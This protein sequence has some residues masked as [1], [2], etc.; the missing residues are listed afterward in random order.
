MMVMKEP[1]IRRNVHRKGL[2]ALPTV[3]RTDLDRI[4]RERIAS[5]LE[6]QQQKDPS[7]K[8]VPAKVRDQL[9]RDG[10]AVIRGL[11]APELVDELRERVFKTVIRAGLG[12]D[13]R[14]DAST[15][16]L[17]RAPRNPKDFNGRESVRRV[18]TS[19]PYNVLVSHA[20]KALRLVSGPAWLMQTRY[21]RVGLPGGLDFRLP[22][23]QDAF[24]LPESKT[25]RTVWIPLHRCPRNLGGLRVVPRSHQRGA[26]LHDG[27]QGIPVRGAALRWKQLAFEVGDAVIFD[28]HTIHASG[29]N[30][31]KDQVR[32]SVDFRLGT[33]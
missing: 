7:V 33:L 27:R 28:G 13:H 23:H 30:R 32:F 11:L 26:F 6:A 25:F 24:Y 9:E 29:I 18:T 14:G 5:S 12:R 10:F 2:A 21:L 4:T 22:P 19:R 31:T 20:I 17:S 15:F 16:Y 3:S 8:L 1:G